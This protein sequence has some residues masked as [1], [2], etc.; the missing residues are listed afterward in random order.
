MKKLK[1]RKYQEGGDP[2]KK[3]N[4]DIENGRM[5]NANGTDYFLPTE[6]EK[7][8]A[9]GATAQIPLS[10]AAVVK[11]KKPLF[12]Y[13]GNGNFNLNLG[14]GWYL[15]YDRDAN[16]RFALGSLGGTAAIAGAA[17]VGIP[18]TVGTM[19]AGKAGSDAVNGVT[20][21]ITGKDWDTHAGNFV[22]KVGLSPEFGVLL[23]PGGLVGGAYGAIYGEPLSTMTF[24]APKI[25]QGMIKHGTRPSAKSIP[26]LARYAHDLI[27]NSN[28]VLRA[29]YQGRYVYD[30]NSYIQNARRIISNAEKGRDFTADIYK[31]LTNLNMPKR[32]IRPGRWSDK[33]MDNSGGAYYSTRY[34]DIHITP[35]IDSQ[36]NIA[37][38]DKSSLFTGA[39]EGTHGA[40]DHL[41]D[42]FGE[43]MTVKDNA[44]SD[45]F[46]PNK[47]H[48]VVGKYY[49]DFMK[50]KGNHGK[51]PE[52]TFANYMGYLSGGKDY[53]YNTFLDYNTYI[54]GVP[55]KT[56]KNFVKDYW[57]YLNDFTLF[58]EPYTFPGFK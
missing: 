44:I 57:D 13:T 34:K 2:F 54:E 16:A 31:K 46:I 19:L 50:V 15:P 1:P 51:S 38:S 18:A 9:Q 39:H 17:T 47:S 23:N 43:E 27:G 48:P 5:I 14:G 25:M 49:D 40:Q 7:Q 20:K 35:T 6:V 22:N 36:S 45:Y 42:A 52:E 11:G 29:V 53:D 26:F 58:H 55:Q 37:R 10:K 24:T 28:E 3:V 41:R 56:T 12:Q 33:S 30:K 4:P 32:D 21:A 8:L